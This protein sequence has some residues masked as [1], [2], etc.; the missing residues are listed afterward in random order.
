MGKIKHLFI[1]LLKSKQSFYKKLYSFKIVFNDFLMITA[2][3]DI[4]F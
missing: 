1:H 3:I 4:I 2:I